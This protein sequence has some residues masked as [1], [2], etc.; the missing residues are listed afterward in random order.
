[1]VDLLDNKFD[2]KDMTIKLMAME[3][4]FKALFDQEVIDLL[5]FI[6]VEMKKKEKNELESK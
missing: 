4:I 2:Q 6:M 5:P 1:M 3:V